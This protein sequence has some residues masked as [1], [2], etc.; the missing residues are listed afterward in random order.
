MDSNVKS[1]SIAYSEPCHTSELE[2]F[3]K[4]VKS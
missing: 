2:L 4:I 3:A 1:Y